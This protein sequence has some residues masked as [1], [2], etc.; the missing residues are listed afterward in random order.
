LIKD[1]SFDQSERVLD[2]IS[3]LEPLSF[4]GFCNGGYNLGGFSLL[5]DK[6]MHSSPFDLR[7]MIYVPL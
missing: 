7:G 4:N 1:E 3:Q 5:G 6:C 2:K